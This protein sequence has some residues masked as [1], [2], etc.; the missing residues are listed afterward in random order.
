[1][2]RTRTIGVILFTFV[3]VFL[4]IFLW[5]VCPNVYMNQGFCILCCNIFM[6]LC[7]I[8]IVSRES[9]YF[10]EPIVFVYFMYYMIFVFTPIL[11]I[12]TNNVDIFGTDTM[13]GCFKGTVIFAIGF[14]A[15]LIGYYSN[16]YINGR[17]KNIEQNDEII[18][19]YDK[20]SLLRYSY[21]VWAL[22]VGIYL[23]YNAM[24]GRSLLYMLT[25]GFL[26]RGLGTSGGFEI[27]FLS[28]IIYCGSLPMMNILVNEKSKVIKFIVFFVTCVPVA[29]RG[30]RS[31]LIIP[32]LAPFVYYYIKR[33]KSPSMKILILV[34]VLVI[35]MLGFI[36]NTRSSMRMGNGLNVEGYTFTD[37][38]DGAIDYF[39]S[40]KAFYGAVQ[41]YPE[42]FPY[43]YGKQLLYAVVMYIPRAIWP[44]KPNGWI[45]E[46]IGNSTNEVARASGSAWP[47]IGEYYTDGGIIEVV[48]VMFILGALFRKMKNMYESPRS[49]SSL[50]VYS[51]L[52]P[53]LIPIIAYGYTA[54]NLPTI[55]FMILPLLGQRY[56]V[57]G[58]LIYRNEGDT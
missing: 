44:N 41:Q 43:T 15:L 13:S 7:L 33:K 8:Y 32:L 47:N 16:I 23:L 18:L 3:T 29:T 6:C 21:I 36:G 2:Q 28:M 25:F 57:K 22:A 30:F 54:G 19:E 45:Q 49:E 1:M 48:I 53:G 5:S 17:F 46:V 20:D 39:S 27:D 42:I 34:F 37:G 12:L 14:I 11:N 56:L 38:I 58:S 40:Y 35:F 10:F 9:F 55:V 24:T 50:L 4:Y 52:L 26:S 51:L 31:A